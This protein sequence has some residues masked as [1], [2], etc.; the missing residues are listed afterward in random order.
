MKILI[1]HIL[2]IMLFLT[3]CTPVKLLMNVDTSLESNAVVYRLTYPNSL[4]DK[5]SGKRLNVS[6]GPYQVTDADL[7][8][9][10]TGSQAEDPDSFFTA[11]STRKSGEAAK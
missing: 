11:K 5:I 7:S 6:F 3:G 8:W 9:T 4:S 1:S 10:R 2:L